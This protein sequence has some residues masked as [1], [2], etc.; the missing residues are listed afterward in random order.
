[1]LAATICGAPTSD[2]VYWYICACSDETESMVAITTERN[3]TCAVMYDFPMN[4]IGF[5]SD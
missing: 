3:F 1:M 4:R 5:M 2:T